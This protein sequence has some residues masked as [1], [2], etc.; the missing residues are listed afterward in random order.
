MDFRE[1]L[2]NLIYLHK[3]NRQDNMLQIKKILLINL[4]P[5]IILKHTQKISFRKKNTNF[6][7]TAINSIDA[8]FIKNFILLSF[9]CIHMEGLELYL[10]ITL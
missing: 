10:P 1:T 8:L 6:L 9:L 5:E 3:F 4:E 2:K 7:K